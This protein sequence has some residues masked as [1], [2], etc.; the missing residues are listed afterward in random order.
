MV[1]AVIF[2][3]YE[4]LI[5]H[6]HS[7]LY[8]SAQIAA[9]AGIPVDKFQA[10]WR[11]VEQKRTLGELT[12]E[13]TLEFILKEN[14]RYSA[15]LMA[16]IVEKRKT[17]KRDCFRHLHPEVIP[18]LKRLKENGLAIGLI[19]NCFSEEA[20]IIR[21]SVLFPYFD[22]ALL[23]FEQ[24]LQK[25]DERIFIRCMDRLGVEAAECVYVGDGG[26]LELETASKFVMKEVQA[27]WYLTEDSTHPV[28]RKPSFPQAETP[29]EILNYV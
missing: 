13:D 26:S 16:K 2:D 18:L 4:T 21:E 17:I 9:D 29:L 27:V 10:L 7:P 28:K 25:P 19:S 5:T 3:M 11:P 20:E 14:Q 6:Y 1:K 12:F 15:E 24:G 23:S 8:F 22:A